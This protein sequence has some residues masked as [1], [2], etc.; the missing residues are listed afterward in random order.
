MKSGSVD[1]I[2]SESRPGKC[3][4]RFDRIW[5]ARI[6]Q[7]WS[8]LSLNISLSETSMNLLSFKKTEANS[9][10]SLSAVMLTKRE[11]NKARLDGNKVLLVKRLASNLH[12][13]VAS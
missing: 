2:L 3:L 11:N 5:M 1:E 9:F 10:V 6:V 7:I 8:L 12:K 4:E 13:S